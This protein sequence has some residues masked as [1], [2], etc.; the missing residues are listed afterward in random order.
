M[1][2]F[3]KVKPIKANRFQKA[4]ETDGIL[5]VSSEQVKLQ[6]NIIDLTEYD[7]KLI[8]AFREAI[9]PQAEEVV[10]AFYQ[11]ILQKWK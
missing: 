7:L 9:E 8:H 6:V 10:D 11:T 5:D 2:I 3:K 1:G 4:N